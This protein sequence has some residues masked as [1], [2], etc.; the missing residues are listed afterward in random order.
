MSKFIDTIFD[1]ASPSAEPGNTFATNQG[2]N[3]LPPRGKFLDHFRI[4]LF[5]DVTV[6]PVTLE[7]ALAAL[8]QFTFKAGQETRIQLSASDILAVMATFYKELPAVW[9][10]TDSAGTTYCLGLKIPIHETIDPSTTYSW[11]ATYAAQTNF[12]AVKLCIEAVYLSSPSAEH[13]KIIVPISYTTPGSTGMSAVNAR[14]Q[15]LG[16]LIGLMLFTPT[17]LSDGLDVMDIQRIQLVESGKQTSM[18]NVANAKNILGQSD[19]EALGPIGE[20]LIDYAYW[21]MSDD[22]IDVKA[23]YLEFIADVEATAGATRLIPII[24]KS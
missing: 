4:S 22:P 17:R 14:L 19:Y 1:A 7:T 2:P 21:D 9:E 3:I 13:A 11:S 6:A 16:N 20:V 10:N 18:L 15:N 23:G 8:S 12:S 24:A 5:G